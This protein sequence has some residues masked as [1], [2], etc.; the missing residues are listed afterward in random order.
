MGKRSS[1]FESPFSFLS[2]SIIIINNIVRV[3]YLVGLGLLFDS[4]PIILN[5]N[6][7]LYYKNMVIPNAIHYEQRNRQI[8]SMGQS[9]LKGQVNV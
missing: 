4:F 6:D 3:Q 1:V 8:H 7:E 5:D 9:Q 2:H